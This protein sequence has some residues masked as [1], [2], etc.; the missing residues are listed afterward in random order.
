MGFSKTDAFHYC[1]IKQATFILQQQVVEVCYR[2]YSE[3]HRFLN[4]DRNA[5]FWLCKAP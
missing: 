2:L 1:E 4:S 5:T 3:V